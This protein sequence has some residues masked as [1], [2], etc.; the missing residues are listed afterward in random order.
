MTNYH[1]DKTNI[2]INYIET[3]NKVEELVIKVLTKTLKDPSNKV[4]IVTNGC[5]GWV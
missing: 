2:P 1:F 3:L 5:Q 4:R